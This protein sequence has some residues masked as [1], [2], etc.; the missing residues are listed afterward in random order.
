MSINLTGYSATYD[1][2]ERLA[3]VWNDKGEH[4]ATYMRY[5]GESPRWGCEW[6]RA[7]MWGFQSR[8]LD[9][10]MQLQGGA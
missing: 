4:V 10:L 8:D 6:H 2:R 1:A 3:R 7:D 9:T 5:G